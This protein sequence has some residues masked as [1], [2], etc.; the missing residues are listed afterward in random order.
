MRFG[1]LLLVFF[2]FLNTAI[3][4]FKS[5]FA[6]MLLLLRYCGQKGPHADLASSGEACMGSCKLRPKITTKDSL[7]LNFKSSYGG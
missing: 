5:T 3:F 6:R 1:K 7:K 2:F 4:I